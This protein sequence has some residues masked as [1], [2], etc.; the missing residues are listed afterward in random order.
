[1]NNHIFNHIYQL[2]NVVNDNCILNKKL[3]RYASNNPKQDKIL[4]LRIDSA[5]ENIKEPLFILYIVTFE[6]FFINKGINPF[7]FLDKM[8]LNFIY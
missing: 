6:C 4:S 3:F 7:I 1:M 2:M 5:F 8:F